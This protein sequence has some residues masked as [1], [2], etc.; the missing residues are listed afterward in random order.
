MGNEELNVFKSMSPE[1]R[2]KWMAQFVMDPDK[3][4]KQGFSNTQVIDNTFTDEAEQLC[5]MDELGGPKFLNNKEHA[6]IACEAGDFGKPLP[7]ELPS[8]AAAG[9]M[10]YRFSWA[11]YKSR[12]GLENKAGVQTEADLTTTEYNEVKAAMQGDM[13]GA[14]KGPSGKRKIGTAAP[15]PKATER[16]GQTLEVTGSGAN[17]GAPQTQRHGRQDAQGNQRRRGLAPRAHH[18]GL[19]DGH[20]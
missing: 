17:D 11:V 5:T 14:Q 10:Q 18:Q 12:I 9:V 20:A 13:Q 7:H 1:E 3:C 19:P 2:A 4:K 15:A 8:L 6:R 16:R